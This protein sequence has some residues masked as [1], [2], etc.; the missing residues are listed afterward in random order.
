MMTRKEA[1][2]QIKAFRKMV[3][4]RYDHMGTSQKV[5]GLAIVS[6]LIGVA[7]LVGRSVMTGECDTKSQK[8]KLA[9]SV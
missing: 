2:R 9:P 5:A 4:S 8:D 1:K 7:T 3:E 6:L